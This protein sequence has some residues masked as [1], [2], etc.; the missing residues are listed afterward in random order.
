MPAAKDRSDVPAR[1]GHVAP[2]ETRDPSKYTA[3]IEGKRS[4]LEH[5][6]RPFDTVEEAVAWARERA[7]VV[8]VRLR[9]ENLIRSAGE[10][11]LPAAPDMPR[12]PAERSAKDA[13]RR[14]RGR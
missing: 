13:E 7:P 6:P 10:L 3:H 11:P 8:L 12:W 5:A 9:D 2:D 4:V 14:A 1:S